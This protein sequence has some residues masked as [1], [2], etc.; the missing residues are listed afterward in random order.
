[1]RGDPDGTS[2]NRDHRQPDRVPTVGERCDDGLVNLPA[3]AKLPHD[4]AI[5]RAVA[6]LID[7]G[8]Q[9]RCV[10]AA[11]SAIR[12]VRDR[13]PN[14]PVEE[15]AV[16]PAWLDA[17]LDA[18][19]MWLVT[20]DTL[21]EHR[22]LT[23]GDADEAIAAMIDVT[24]QT[25]AWRD[26]DVVDGWLREA[27]DFACC[28]VKMPAALVAAGRVRTPIECAVLA[29]LS[30]TRA[31]ICDGVAPDEAVFAIARAVGEATNS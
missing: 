9:P 24:R 8:D 21:D 15:L 28:A 3:W 22:A 17:Q 10:R 18:L 5:A 7:D 27:A 19:D 20:R 30:T 14:A 1:M 2:C 13:M 6:T 23:E 29:A 16:D 12:A 31:L 25:C 11:V 4:A 26:F